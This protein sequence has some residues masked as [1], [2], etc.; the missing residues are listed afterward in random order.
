MF[1]AFKEC[2]FCIEVIPERA[3]RCPHRTSQLGSGAVGARIVALG[4]G[5]PA[6]SGGIPP[7]VCGTVS[8]R[9]ATT[10]ERRA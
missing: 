2:P 9:R 10:I 8:N 7:R 4:W 3:T 1:K 5:A 6:L